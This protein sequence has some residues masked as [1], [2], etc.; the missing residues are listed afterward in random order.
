[1][2]LTRVIP[3]PKC[4]EVTLW[5]FLA[6]DL[7]ESLVVILSLSRSF[8]FGMSRLTAPQTMGEPRHQEDHEQQ[9]IGFFRME[10][11]VN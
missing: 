10:A 6:G 9:Q 4:Q 1:M 7:A 8:C 5:F 11:C 3:R 2:H